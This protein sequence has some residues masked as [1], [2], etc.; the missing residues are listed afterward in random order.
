MKKMNE[1]DVVLVGGGWTGGILGKELSEA[2][3]TVVCLE[4]GGPQTPSDDFTVP[5]MRDELALGIR[6]GMMVNTTDS[7]ETIRNDIKETALPYRRLGSYLMGTGVGGASTHWNGHTWRWTD[8]EFKIRTRYEEKYGKKYI[9]EDMTI[10]DWGITY[11]ELE[12]YYDKF[13]KTAGISGKA[14]NLKGKKI[15]TGNVFEAPRSSEYPLPPIETTYAGEL[16]GDAAKKMGYH[17]FPRPTANASRAYTNPDGAKFGECQYC[18]HCERFG[19]EANAKGGAHMTVLPFAMKQKSFEM[20]TNSWVTRVERDASGTKATGVTYI[21][22]TTGEEH[23]QPAKMVMLCAYGMNN[24][25]L[26]LASGIGEAYD[27]ATGKGLVGKNYCYQTGA[28]AMLFF[29]DKLFHPFMATAGTSTLID[30]FHANWDFDRSPFGY[31]GGSI[32]GTAMY[33]GRPI[34]WRP[35]PEGTPGWGSKW[36]E[37]TTK[38]YDRAMNIVASGSVMPNRANYL[39]LDPTY[40][41]RF[42]MPLMRMTFDYK[43]NERKLSAHSA[44]IINEIAAAMN[45]THLNKASARNSWSSVP[46]QSTHNT[47]GTIMGTNPHNSVTNKYGQVW[48]VD[49]LFIMGASLFPHNSAYNPTGPVGAI[50]YMTADIIKN[51]YIKNPGKLIDA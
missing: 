8:D 47:G 40:R 21:N 31:I 17:P 20:R 10:Q 33:G 9:P 6:H 45:P 23:F 38:W 36:K 18:G 13:E 24:V 1:V 41:N 49:N 39:D 50:A 43:D 25:H 51:V 14:G 28:G 32:I 12:K 30:D 16:F 26:M 48:G 29:E 15:A 35:V 5:R 22:L 11:K 46:Y 4:R 44:K 3:M 34:Q 2:G 37:E 42:G 19:C 7:T 27:P